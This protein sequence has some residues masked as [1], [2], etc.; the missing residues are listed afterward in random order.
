MKA[1]VKHHSKASYSYFEY[2]F[3]CVCRQYRLAIGKSK[4]PAWISVFISTGHTKAAVSAIYVLVN[5]VVLNR[6]DEVAHM[7]PIVSE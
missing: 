1:V 2:L 5:E 7:L 4:H 6:G 3:E